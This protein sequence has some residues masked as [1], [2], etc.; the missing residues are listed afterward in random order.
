MFFVYQLGHRWLSHLVAVTVGALLAALIVLPATGVVIA[1]PAQRRTL[2]QTQQQFA[3]A[4][5]NYNRDAAKSYMLKWGNQANNAD[6][7]YYYDATGQGIDCTHFVSQALLAGGIDDGG[8]INANPL[9]SWLT[10]HNLAT[11]D[12]ESSRGTMPTPPAGLQIGDIILYA[13]YGHSS[14]DHAAIV[15]NAAGS[16]SRIAEHSFG[17]QWDPTTKSYKVWNENDQPWGDYNPGGDTKYGFLLI[18]NSPTPADAAQFITQSAY[19]TVMTDQTFSISYVLQNTGTSTWSDGAGYTLECKSVCMGGQNSNFNGQSVAPGQQWQFTIPLTAPSSPGTYITGWTLAH[20]GSTFGPGV[21]IVV[22]VEQAVDDDALVSQSASQTV[23][24]TQQFDVSFTLANTGNTTWT[25]GGGYALVCTANCMGASTAGFNGQSVMPSQQFQFGIGL[26]A[27]SSN[28]TYTTTWALE[29]NGT[30]FG[31][32]SLQINV[33]VQGPQPGTAQLVVIQGVWGYSPAILGQHFDAQ[34][35]VKNI[36]DAPFDFAQLYIAGHGP[37]GQN[38]DLGGDNNRTPIQPGQ[39]RTIFLSTNDFGS[40]CPSCGQGN[41]W[42]NAS[43]Q[44]PDGSWWAPPAI[45]GASDVYSF[46]VQVPAPNLV[47]IQGIWGYSPAVLGQRF[48]AQYTVQNIGNAPFDLAQLYIAGHGPNN[49]NV[50]LGGDNNRTPIQPGEKRTIFLATSDFG[51]NC[52]SCE[53]GNYWINVSVQL[54][55]GSWWA[56]PAAKGASDEY[57]FPVQTPAPNLVVIQGIWGY[58][59]AVLGQY[60]DAQYTVQ[61]IGNAPF[62]LAQ[63]Y[64]A[65]HGPNNQ[66]VDLG[67]DGNRTP[68]QPGETRKIFLSTND[69]AGN[70]SSCGPGNYWIN[71]SVQLPD[72]SWWA[73]PAA[74]GASDEYWFPVKAPSA[75]AISSLSRPWFWDTRRRMRL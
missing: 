63:L 23:L 32:S 29:H 56:P 75:N 70:C 12:I 20:N 60:F 21:S 52:S 31:Q 50:D 53:P 64:I 66:N 8:Q 69:F 68:I 44:L 15:T 43:V 36:G 45:N 49:Q 17:T 58:S 65:G 39:T 38:V 67:G 73:P 47:V 61:N 72:G 11:L 22:T 24:P 19:P 33:T 35:T 59:P 71:V 10:S 16:A 40:N 27:P 46:P 37:N 55:D 41:Y 62:D 6:G 26:R 48:D 28:G 54:P 57:W 30:P 1:A 14:W 42:I 74:N 2:T 4:T 34:Y 7:K 25:D 3:P 9:A 51:S 18:N 5:T 13:W